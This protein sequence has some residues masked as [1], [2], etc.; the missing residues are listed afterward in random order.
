[1]NIEYFVK[2]TTRH[3]LPCSLALKTIASFSFVVRTRPGPGE[4][5]DSYVSTGHGPE[6]L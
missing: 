5:L 1:M 2:F 3:Q 6:V 4:T